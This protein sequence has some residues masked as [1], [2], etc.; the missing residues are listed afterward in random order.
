MVST[1]GVDRRDFAPVSQ[2]AK[3]AREQVSTELVRIS[4]PSIGLTRL[5]AN[6]LFLD[7]LATVDTSS[8][9]VTEE[10]CSFHMVTDMR[11]AFN[12]F[13]KGYKCTAK[14]RQLTREEQDKINPH[15]KSLMWYTAVTVT[16][17]AQ[18][19][20]LAKNSAVV[21]KTKDKRV[22]NITAARG[23]A[24]STPVSAQPAQPQVGASTSKKRSAGDA[25]LQPKAVP[26]TK[27]AKA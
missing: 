14:S 8:G 11:K 16:P 12:K 17:E 15:R 20:Y 1:P 9:P 21:E 23:S 7:F 4:T 13:V 25:E 24:P 19:D 5:H 22:A 18:K 10:V 3:A 2:R 6:K 26:K 27:K